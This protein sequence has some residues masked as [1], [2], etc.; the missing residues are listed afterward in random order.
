[1]FAVLR[2][3]LPALFA[4]AVLLY[5]MRTF[6]DILANDGPRRSIA[7][8]KSMFQQQMSLQRLAT[9][10]DA[11]FPEDETTSH[12][13]G[14]FDRSA[15]IEDRSTRSAAGAISEGLATSPP[16]VNWTNVAA[17]L[18]PIVRSKRHSVPASGACAS[19]PSSNRVAPG[20]PHALSTGL[21]LLTESGRLRL[22]SPGLCA[23]LLLP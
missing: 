4:L 2:R 8:Q 23:R 1:M 19:V 12:M 14:S 5:N 18:R 16:G 15:A 6:H 21:F 11:A 10:T 17:T 7:A 9:M 22:V 3:F 20:L 13:L